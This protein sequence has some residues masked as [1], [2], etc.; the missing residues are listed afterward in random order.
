MHYCHRGH[1]MTTPV[2]DD[3][4]D[5]RRGGGTASA[6]SPRAAAMAVADR[7]E[8]Y[9]AENLIVLVQLYEQTDLQ[10]GSTLRLKS[11]LA[12]PLLARSSFS[13]LLEK[14]TQ[15]LR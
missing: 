13:H 4:D 1:G 7:A 5:G 9:P 2:T 12:R 14:H 6:T 11:T 15:Y 8:I 3:D 10:L